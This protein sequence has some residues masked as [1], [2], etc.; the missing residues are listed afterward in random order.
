MRSS[1]QSDSTVYGRP[2]IQ[3]ARQIGCHL[4]T[5]HRWRATGVLD[6]N[7]VRRRLRMTRVG[8]RWHVR[9]EDLAD[10]FAALTGKPVSIPGGEHGSSS[11]GRRGEIDRVLKDLDAA[12]IK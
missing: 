9:D 6:L 2:L 12:G 10:F 7:G 1:T 8:G 3:K 5:L 11:T 4:A